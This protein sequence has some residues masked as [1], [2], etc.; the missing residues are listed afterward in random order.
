MPEPAS[1]LWRS[2]DMVLLQLH[3]QRE[4]A[5][6]TIFK[7]GQLGCVQFR[8]MNPNTSAFQ[9]LFTG[10]VRRCEESERRL[11]YFEDQL[12][13]AK[14]STH[15]TTVVDSATGE[16]LDSLEPKLEAMESELKDLNSKWEQLL[17]Q[18]NSMKE[19]YEVLTQ[20]PS[21]FRGEDDAGHLQVA[22][23]ADDAS[24][25][26]GFRQGGLRYLTGVI[27]SDRAALFERLVYRATRGNM[28][29]RTVTAKEQFE[30]PAT[31]DMVEK[32]VFVVFFSAQ[33]AFDKI[34]K[35]CESM[36]ATLYPYNIDSPQ[37]VQQTTLK[38]SDTMRDLDTTIKVTKDVRADIVEKVKQNLFLWK[39]TVLVEKSVY[40]VLNQLSFKGQTVVAECWAPKEDLDN[41]QR[42]LVEAEKSSGAQVQS[43]MDPIETH[44]QPPTYFKTNSFTKIHQSIVDS[45]GIARY[46]EINPAV[47]SCMTFP[48]LFGIMYGDIGHGFII[49]LVAALFIWKEKQLLA[50]NINE[51]IAMVFGGRYILILMGLFAIYTG[52][53]YND[54]FG[55]MISPFGENTFWVFPHDKEEWKT[56]CGDDYNYWFGGKE[57][58]AL[59]AC[60]VI[61]GSPYILGIDPNWCET[62]NKLEFYNSLKM[63]MAVILGVI[64]MSGGL[65]L[66]LLNHIYFKDM[67]HVWF[68]F[69]PEIIFLIFTFGYMCFMI[70]VKWNTDWSERFRTEIDLPGA[71]TPGP[72]FLRA[73]S[74]LEAQTNF[75]LM[76]GSIETDAY[77][78]VGAGFQNMVQVGLLLCS[79]VAVPLLLIP[80]PVI[81]YLHNKHTSYGELAEHH[82]VQGL[83]HIQDL[84]SSSESRN[85][86]GDDEHPAAE[87]HEAF[88]MSEVVIKQ[89]IHTIEFVLGCVSNTASYLRLW[90][91]SLAHAQLSEVFWNF[92]MIMPL[93]M[94]KGTG[95][96]A[97]VGFA[98]WFF[99]SLMVLCGMESLS[100]FLHALRLHWVEFQNKFYFGDGTQFVP[101]NIKDIDELAK[102]DI[103]TE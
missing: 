101:Y 18:K 35:L 89:V 59:Q 10:D 68:G 95:V 33:R 43:F 31:G 78:F 5:H 61:G 22:H 44:D 84:S 75:F 87:Q 81:E 66:S 83:M 73:P 32:T 38:V 8:D 2:Q 25:P 54:F 45:Y 4:A 51:I 57:A 21:F 47:F 46:K 96:F 7:L 79:L 88:D 9:R 91:L 53:L 11:R 63:K 103:A 30:D 34:K 40:D 69:V 58:N 100:A 55:M 102:P 80:I 48:F 52:F 50:S 23:Q 70:L 76:P 27:S 94:D 71:S 82:E 98:V 37:E 60:K 6:D 15:V 39:K 26:Q 90:A 13:R 99:A 74:L 29:M 19:H 92:A 41:V 72:H 85:V 67:K 3:M 86:G 77:V 64:Q 16:T 93:S 65:V 14:D 42:A 17:V 12:K 20:P 1:G 24:E 28:F 49:T 97:F 56:M 36:Q 62:E